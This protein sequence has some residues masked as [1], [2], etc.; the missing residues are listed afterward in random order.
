MVGMITD[1]KGKISIDA[2]SSQVL[3]M[4]GGN[5]A[6]PPDLI[7]W[8]SVIAICLTAVFSSLTSG[9]ISNGKESAGFKYVPLILILSLMIFIVGKMFLELVLSEFFSV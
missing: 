2:E 8:F 1:M 9:V 4:F 7:F 6:I 3:P 5:T